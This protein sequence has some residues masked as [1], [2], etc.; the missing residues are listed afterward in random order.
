M[1]TMRLIFFFLSRVYQNLIKAF[2]LNQGNLWIWKWASR[3]FLCPN[4]VSQNPGLPL[5]WLDFPFD[6]RVGSSTEDSKVVSLHLTKNHQIN[7]MLTKTE[8]KV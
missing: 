5:L 2:W 6:L 3:D 7:Q 8:K 1:Y 4:Q